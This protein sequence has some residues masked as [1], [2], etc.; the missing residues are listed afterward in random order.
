MSL[1][2]APKLSPLTEKLLLTIVGSDFAYWAGSRIASGMVI[3]TVMGTPPDIMEKASTQEQSRINIFME[4]IL[5]ISGRVQGIMKDAEISGSIARYDLGSIKAPTFLLSARDDLY[6][7]FAGA[8]YAAT[9]IPH[10]KFIAY[11]TGGHMLAGHFAEAL[12]EIGE[13][14]KSQQNGIN[15]P[16][17]RHRHGRRHAEAHH[18]VHAAAVNA[19]RSGETPAH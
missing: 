19:Q 2:P 3:K 11:E 14:L 5:P 12:G 16:P 8:E 1:A 13:F 4:H 18:K 15:R 6:G 17:Q 10:A 9:Q 7:T